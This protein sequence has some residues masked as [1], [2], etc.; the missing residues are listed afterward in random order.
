MTTQQTNQ[1]SQPAQTPATVPTRAGAGR[2]AELREFLAALLRFQCRL[3]GAEAG[4]VYLSPGR[5]AAGGV[6][7]THREEGEGEFDEASLQRLTALAARATAGV[8]TPL[9]E[10]VALQDGKRYYTTEASHIALATPLRAEGRVEGATLVLAPSRGLD[11]DQAL[12][13]L[14]LTT[15]RFEAYLWRQSAL[16][17]SQQKV[18]LKET[19]ELLDRAQQ[20]QTARSMASLMAGELR[21]RFGCTRV[22]IGLIAADRVRVMAVSGADD[23]DPRSPAVEAIEAAMEETALQDAEVLYPEPE[24]ATPGTRRVLHQH[25]RLSELFGPAAIVSIPLRIDGGLVGV[26]VLERDQTDPFPEASLP[27]MRLVAEFIGPAVYTR[28]LADRRT[29]QVLRDDLRDLAG[30]IVG[31]RRTLTKAI[32]AAV[33]LVFL[34]L[35]FVPIPDRVVASFELRAT[36]S[37]AIVPP[38]AGYLERAHVRP[39]DRVAAGDLL[40]EMKTDDLR[41]RLA[42]AEARRENLLVRRDAAVARGERAEGRQAQAEIDE[43]EATIELVAESLKA[44]RLTSPIAGVV[45]LGDLDRLSGAPV[46]AN[47]VLLEIVADGTTA[48]LQIAERDFDRIAVGQTGWIAPRGSPGA[49]IPVIVTRINPVAQVRE[50]GS[51]YLVEA[52]VDSASSLQPGM[53]GSV[54]LR[55]GWTTGLGTIARPLIDAARLRLWW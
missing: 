16:H 45:S 36:V 32:A 55:D 27:L 13:Q 1:P 49:R 50:T 2:S 52:S 26:M 18:V 15:A 9:A 51:V 46:D 11:T 25:A 5:G 41:L 20:G 3:I 7:V 42:E 23:L 24:G 43:T 19:L 38:F 33:L 47:Q 48:V 8:G 35:A 22:S 34:L 10:P 21:R 39:G 6:I 30:A 40:V 17:E 54:R 4:A 14:G 44:A 12:A 53:T 29:P 37:R 31:P 28:R